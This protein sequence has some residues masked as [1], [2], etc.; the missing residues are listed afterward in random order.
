MGFEI[1]IRQTSLGQDLRRIAVEQ[2]DGALGDL[3]KAS[4]DLPEQIHRL[5]KRTKKLRSLVRMIGVHLPGH[6]QE[7]TALRDMA[8]RLAG[9]RDAGVMLATFDALFGT[10]DSLRARLD[11]AKVAAYGDATLQSRLDHVRGDLTALRDR[12]ARWH[13]K[14]KGFALLETGIRQTWRRCS[15][16]MEQVRRSPQQE[17][18]HDWRKSVKDHAYQA[19]ILHPIWPEGL[20][21]GLTTA[22][23]LEEQLGQIHDLDV[24]T[25]WLRQQPEQTEAAALIPLALARRASLLTDSLALGTR[26]FAGSDGD[27]ALRWSTWLRLS[28]DAAAAT[29]PKPGKS[30]RPAGSGRQLALDQRNGLLHPVQGNK[31]AKPRPL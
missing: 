19:R 7:L 20:A 16:R 4:T 12:V 24:L 29:A 23:Q 9:L 30:R 22:M 15:S 28:H 11:Q 5:R 18:I 21:P 2:I 3:A 17:A 31:P 13:L 25:D 8:R 27:L 26:L 10:G 6:R 14:A 1:D